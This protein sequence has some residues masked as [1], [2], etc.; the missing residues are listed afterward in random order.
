[1]MPRGKKIEDFITQ[2]LPKVKLNKLQPTTIAGQ[3]AWAGYVDSNK[4]RHQLVLVAN[5]GNQKGVIVIN[6]QAPPQHRT[7]LSDY[8][9]RLRSI[10]LLSENDANLKPSEINPKRGF[11]I[12]IAS[13]LVI[14][15]YFLFEDVLKNLLSSDN[16]TRSYHYFVYVREPKEGS[17]P[18]SRL[19]MNYPRGDYLNYKYY[20]LTDNG[21]LSEGKYGTDQIQ[22]TVESVKVDD[23]GLYLASPSYCQQ[24]SDCSYRSNFCDVGAFNPYHQFITPW[25]CG[26]AQFQGFGPEIELKQSLGC[27]G[28]VE[29][30]YADIRCVSNTC[31]MINPTPACK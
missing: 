29:L 15:D 3:T 26:T 24:D 23:L 21:Q 4:L 13:S 28:R 8:V 1:M 19:E 7:M 16:P 20:L 5:F 30:K 14:D 6:A 10:S 12:R 9:L 18:S 31:Q 11:F 25:G 22:I 17:Q 27:A 2:S